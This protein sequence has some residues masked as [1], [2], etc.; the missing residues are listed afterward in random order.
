VS[1]ALHYTTPM[2]VSR[3]IVTKQAYLVIH[4]DVKPA[5]SAEVWYRVASAEAGRG[6][7]GQE[8][9]ESHVTLEL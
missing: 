2:F 5:F 1:P 6:V 7:E 4:F 3:I 8:S 9:L